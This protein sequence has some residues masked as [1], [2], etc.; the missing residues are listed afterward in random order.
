M[1]L[2]ILDNCHAY[3][4]LLNLYISTLKQFY[5]VQNVA[6]PDEKEWKATLPLE[7]DHGLH[8]VILECHSH[9]Q[10]HALGRYLQDSGDITPGDVTDWCSDRSWQ[11]WCF[12]ISTKR[13]KNTR[14]FARLTLS[15]RK[16]EMFLYAYFMTRIKVMVTFC[17]RRTHS[18]LQ[19]VLKRWPNKVT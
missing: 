4:K 13:D 12:L 7:H 17:C 3:S 6:T 16:R 2:L 14:L 10:A 11:L 5:S 1:I 8:T 9:S 18:H 15:Q 19:S